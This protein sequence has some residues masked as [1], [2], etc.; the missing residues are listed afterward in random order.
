MCAEWVG[1]R[2][3]K[4]YTTKS[5]ESSDINQIRDRKSNLHPAGCSAGH[6]NRCRR[7]TEKEVLFYFPSKKLF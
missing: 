1:R 7:S 2:K 6:Q 3:K 5:I 4:L